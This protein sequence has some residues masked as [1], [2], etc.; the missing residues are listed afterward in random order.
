[1]SAARKL[2]SSSNTSGDEESNDGLIG[3]DEVG[4]E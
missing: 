1:M 3:E 4:V 2:P